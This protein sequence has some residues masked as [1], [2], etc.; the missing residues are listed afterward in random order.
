MKLYNSGT[1]NQKYMHISFDDVYR[2]LHDI[3]TKEYP[4]VFRNHFLHDLQCFHDKYGAVFTLNCFNRCGDYDISNLP[5]SYREEL[6]SA[7][8]WLK[9][10]FH[11]E[12]DRSNYG[13]GKLGTCLSGDITGEIPDKIT[14]SYVKFTTA[15]IRAAGAKSI[16]TFVRLGFFS[17][18]KANIRALQQCPYGITGLLSADDAR[19]SYY[20]TEGENKQLLENGEYY[21]KD[22][23]I[24]LIRSQ[25]R[26]ES[27]SNIDAELASLAAKNSATL[28]IFTHEQRYDGQMKE[29]LAKYLKW[30]AKNG[31]KFEYAFRYNDF[32]V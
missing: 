2:C 11:A 27:V 13:D 7:S 22:G 28:E 1:Q 23:R 19:V 26:I 32:T 31:Y 25:W 24:K 12:T 8:S 30:A 14:A 10:A 16:D 9:F 20:L 17:G 29:K 15:V 18:T 4:S 6:S 3:S 5:D 21:D